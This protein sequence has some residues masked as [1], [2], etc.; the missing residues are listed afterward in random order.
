MHQR[1]VL[2]VAYDRRTGPVLVRVK[3]VYK[4]HTSTVEYHLFNN[5]SWSRLS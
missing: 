2:D 5:I 3:Y 4:K 1:Y